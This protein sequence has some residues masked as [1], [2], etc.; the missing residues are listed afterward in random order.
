V[1][2]RTEA[3]RRF[4][5]RA[6]FPGYP[7]HEDLAA[8]R[9]R[10][11]RSPF[12]R[13]LDRAIAPDARVVEIGC[14]TGQM[15]LYL[16]RADRQIVGADLTRASLELG[17]LAARRYGVTGV[18]FVETDLHHPGLMARSFDVVFTSGVL[19]HTPD[20]RAAFAAVAGLARPGGFIVVGVYNA[21]AR[22]PSRFRRF[23]GRLTGF[24]LLPFDPVLRDRRSD[25]ARREAWLRDQYHHPEEHRHTV[26]QVRSWF[27]DNDVEYLRTFPSTLGEE[28]GDLFARADDDWAAEAWLAQIGWM[29]TLGHEG[30]LFFTIGQQR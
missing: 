30:G 10:G 15:C 13:L 12:A 5:E 3:V 24:R 25:P 7:P 21:V 14:G 4:Y 16:A 1:D 9:A 11:G 2:A 17:A 26:G 22:I 18:H 28:P 27:R 23:V 6:P 8:L 29:W 19:H 20:P